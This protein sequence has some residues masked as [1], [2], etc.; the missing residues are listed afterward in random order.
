MRPSF[1]LIG[2]FLF[3]AAILVLLPAGAQAGTVSGLVTTPGGS[4]ARSGVDPKAI[5]VPVVV[6]I[7]GPKGSARLRTTAPCSHRAVSSSPT[8]AR[9][10][11]RPDG[12]HAQ[13]RRRRPQRLLALG[14]QSPSTSASMA[15]GE[16]KSVTFDRV[17]LIDVLC[18]IHRR[19]KAKILVV[20]NPYYAL[21]A[22]GSPYQIRSVP[23]GE[24][25]LHAWSKSFLRHDQT[26]VVSR[27]TETSPSTSPGGRRTERTIEI[28]GGRAMG[29]AGLDRGRTGTVRSGRP[30]PRGGGGARDH[31]RNARPD[32]ATS[33]RPRPAPS[34]PDT[35]GQPAERRPRSSWAASSSS[36]TASPWTACRAAPPAM[37]HGRAFPTDGRGRWDWVERSWPAALPACSNAAYDA[38][39]SGTAAPPA[40]KQQAEGP[41]LAA[42]EMGMGSAKR[43]VARLREH[44]GIQPAVPGG[45]RRETDLEERRPGHRRVRTHPRHPG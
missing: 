17:G 35:A 40:S 15:K 42:S 39:S 32:V 25:R 37:I 24:Y 27:E 10:R 34:R 4:A 41:M 3:S 2:L 8:L 28:A 14:G 30:R 9:R 1:P 21:T 38:L 7:D 45:L 33:R 20:P 44:S 29:L 26:I 13:R 16:T 11:G 43:F 18:S 12:G 22:V 6:W 23:A 31:D 36:T 19:M 5:A